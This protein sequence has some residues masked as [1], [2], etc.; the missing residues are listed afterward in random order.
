MCFTSGRTEA[1]GL[2]GP[3]DVGVECDGEVC[4]VRDVSVTRRTHRT[5]GIMGELV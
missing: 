2:M 3:D 1:V 5:S 4:V